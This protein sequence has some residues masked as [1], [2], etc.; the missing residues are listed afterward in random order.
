MIRSEF[1]RE[2]DDL[3]ADLTHVRSRLA[4]LAR[5]TPGRLDG[6]TSVDDARA[7]AQVDALRARLDALAAQAGLSRRRRR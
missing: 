3:S 5:R 7:A 4:R 6:P 1:R 2:V